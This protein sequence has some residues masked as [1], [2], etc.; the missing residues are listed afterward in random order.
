MLIKPINIKNIKLQ[1]NHSSV[2]LSKLISQLYLL[3]N[4][5]KHNMSFWDNLCGVPPQ[6]P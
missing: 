2:Q 5:C 4:Y 3:N 6:E 1:F